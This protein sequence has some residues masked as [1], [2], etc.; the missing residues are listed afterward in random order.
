MEI[1]PL[2]KQ[3]DAV[4]LSADGSHRHLS[5]NATVQLQLRLPPPP[6]ADAE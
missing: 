5:N 2:Q 3:V 6:S 4:I 1:E